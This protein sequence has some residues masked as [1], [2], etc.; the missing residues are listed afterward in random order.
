MN[1][2][3]H[4][5]TD[6]EHQETS[7]HWSRTSVDFTTLIA[8]LKRLHLT[9]RKLQWQAWM[10]FETWCSDYL[11]WW[12]VLTTEW[13]RILDWVHQSAGWGWI[14]MQANWLFTTAE[15]PNLECWSDA[16]LQLWLA[17]TAQH[18]DNHTHTNTK[19]NTHTRSLAARTRTRIA[20]WSFAITGRCEP[21]PIPFVY[22]SW[23]SHQTWLCVLC[24]RKYAKYCEGTQISGLCKAFWFCM[25]K[26][27]SMIRTGQ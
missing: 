19:T 22:R 4:H 26:S 7:P 12:S 1:F 5:R 2:R 8:N 23:L 13:F 27:W 16:P 10:S 18:F 3:R 21:G 9:G 6:R 14:T 15:R 17:V 24:V 11:Q 20:N 25:D